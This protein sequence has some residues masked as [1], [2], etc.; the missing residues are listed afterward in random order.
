MKE[1]IPRIVDSVLKNKLEYM[2]AVLIEGV[3]M[4]W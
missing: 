1:Y 3:Q 4:V 2:S